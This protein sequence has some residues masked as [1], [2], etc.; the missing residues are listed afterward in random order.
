M[1][2]FTCPGVGKLRCILLLKK[3]RVHS[4]VLGSWTAH[5]LVCHHQAKADSSGLKAHWWFSI[6][7]ITLE[8]AWNPSEGSNVHGGECALLAAGISSVCFFFHVDG[9]P[10]TVSCLLWFL[11]SRA[12]KWN[13]VHF[14]SS[15][16]RKVIVIERSIP[17]SL[18]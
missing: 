7:S 1:A 9:L 15:L 6:A 11:Q 18:R 13:W 10:L 4:D 12:W 16:C 14:S 5:P 17:I 2:A 8:E 3:V